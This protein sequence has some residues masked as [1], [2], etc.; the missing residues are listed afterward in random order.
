LEEVVLPDLDTRFSVYLPLLFSYLQYAALNLKMAVNDELEGVET[1]TF[2][3]CLSH[4]DQGS[5]LELQ[6]V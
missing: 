2:V 1:K 5:N 4:L 3:A 6:S